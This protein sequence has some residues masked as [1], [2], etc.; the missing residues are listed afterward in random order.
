MTQQIEVNDNQ[1]IRVTLT[2]EYP[3]RPDNYSESAGPYMAPVQHC[4]NIGQAAAYDKYQS[5]ENGI[6]DLV[7]A[8]LAVGFDGSCDIDYA[9]VTYDEEGN[10]VCQSP[11]GDTI[12]YN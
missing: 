11:V 6:H 12:I 5:G 10:E 1:V 8:A 7:E 2:I 3:F 9:V 4:Y